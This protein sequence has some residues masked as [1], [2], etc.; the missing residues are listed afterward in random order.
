[1]KVWILTQAWE[2]EIVGVF[3]DEESAEVELQQILG[4][5]THRPTA[6]QEWEVTLKQVEQ[7]ASNI[8]QPSPAIDKP[9]EPLET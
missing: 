1:M 9:A 4:D 7:A 5:P 8:A 6:I 2:G 3:G